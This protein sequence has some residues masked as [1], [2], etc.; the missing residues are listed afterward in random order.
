MPLYCGWGRSNLAP[1]YVTPTENL[2]GHT[3]PGHTWC[4]KHPKQ[5]HCIWASLWE[6]RL[7]AY[8]KTKTQISFAVT[9]V[10]ATRIVQSLYYLNPKF[11]VSC[12]LLWLYSPVCVGSGRKP[13]RPVLLIWEHFNTGYC[14]NKETIGSHK[15]GLWC[16]TKCDKNPKEV[17]WQ[18]RDTL[19][20][21]YSQHSTQTGKVWGKTCSSFCL[22]LFLSETQ[23][24]WQCLIAKKFILV[25][26]VSLEN[27][28]MYF[29][30]KLFVYL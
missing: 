26:K 29:R 25:L 12:Y 18:F 22:T 3:N 14:P 1:V 10:F 21:G 8:A 5:V 9:F 13:R 20:T 24:T 19:R 30:K 11:Q 7:F 4:D 17:F 28:F 6:N 2:W 23:K 27:T 15:T 16:P